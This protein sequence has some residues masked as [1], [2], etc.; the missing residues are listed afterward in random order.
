MKKIK[1][2]TKSII[3]WIKY[4]ALTLIL[5]GSLVSLVIFTLDIYAKRVL[6]LGEPIVY[7]SHDLWGY[8]PRE[9][10]IYKRF[11]GNIV[12]INNIGARSLKN[13]NDNGNNVIFIGDSITY[14]GSYINDDQTFA[15][16]SC[17]KIQNWTCH[18][19][20]V[21]GYG[22][23][24]MVARSRYDKRISTAPLRVFTFISSDFDRGLSDSN[25]AH[26]ILREPPRL[27]SGLW[28][29]IN[30]V[31]ARATITPKKWF[32][33]KP[34]IKDINL[35]EDAKILKRKFAL[36][37]LVM[38]LQRLEQ[39]GLKFILV[40]S[41]TINE[42]Q[43]PKLIEDNLIITELSKSYNDR[44]IFLSDALLDHYEKNDE[45]IFK[46]NAHYEENGHL[47]VSKYLSPFI[48]KMTQDFKK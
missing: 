16:L 38:E 25:T 19:V 2:N 27:L 37:I 15:S 8:T 20:G 12:T 14:G 32:G 4:A 42:L 36:D 6:N 26:F 47:L 35:L 22:I 3:N 21:N 44:F 46:D 33:K 43:N 10:R 30:F 34:D 13:W 23:L 28:E 40:H 48:Y 29:I 5:S 7:D 41:P 17:L 39:N 18:N 1:F 45:L 24:N 11:N 9:N 31:A